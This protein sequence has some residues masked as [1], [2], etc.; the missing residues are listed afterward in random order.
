MKRK[1]VSRLG[2]YACVD[3]PIAYSYLVAGAYS[4]PR[5]LIYISLLH[6]ER[7]RERKRRG[8][9]EVGGF[10]CE[11]IHISKISSESIW[12]LVRVKVRDYV[13]QINLHY[14]RGAY[15]YKNDIESRAPWFKLMEIGKEKKEEG[16]HSSIRKWLK[17]CDDS[18]VVFPDVSQC[19]PMFPNVFPPQSIA[20][21]QR[22]P[23][24]RPFPF[25]LSL[26]AQKGPLFDCA[27]RRYTF[28]PLYSP[29]HTKGHS[30]LW[31][32]E[33]RKEGANERTNKRR[34]R[35]LG[36]AGRLQAS[37]ASNDN[38]IIV[39]IISRRRMII[40]MSDSWVYTFRFPLPPLSPPPFFF[41]L[42]R[43]RER[44]KID[45]RTG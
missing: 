9:D 39:M 12:S 7:E 13:C 8:V 34:T 20:W 6:K 19:F 32:K 14:T 28:S 15:D 11:F 3:R 38:I 24:H 41:F 5:V 25:P 27:Q 42:K 43:E 16:C 33:G 18:F 10:L 37:S 22:P 26:P 4:R 35:G 30:Y 17:T 29:G 21:H 2:R 36:E 44:R 40:A 1:K 23:L 45:E 31:T